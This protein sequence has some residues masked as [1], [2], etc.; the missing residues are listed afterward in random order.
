MPISGPCPIAAVRR[1]AFTLA[2]FLLAASPAQAVEDV[3]FRFDGRPQRVSGRVLTT[4]VDGGLLV[5]GRDGSLWTVTPED[6]L[7]RHAD[8]EPFE[9]YSQQELSGQ[10]I[11]TLPK[12]F[13]VHRT[14]HYLVCYDT[15]KAYAVWV[16]SLFERLYAAFSNYWKNRDFDLATPRYPLVAIVFADRQQYLSHARPEVGPAADG[17]IGYYSLRTN[18]ITTYDLTGVEAFR[19][20]ES[21]RGSVAEINRMLDR[22]Q[23]EQAVS[24]IIHEATHQIAFNTEFQ[25]RFADVPLW[26]SEGI[27]VYFETP[28]LKSKSGWRNIGGVNYKRLDQFRDYHRNRRGKGSLVSLASSDDRFRD[29]EQG[30]DAYAEAW[31]FNYFLLRNRSDQYHAY[32]KRLAEKKP[33]LFSEPDT[34]LAEFKDAFGG[35]LAEL[36]QDFLRYIEKVK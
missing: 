18:R 10:L 11:E 9:P 3:L 25:V 30:L 16:G 26:V 5:E 19:S 6:L 24:T 20:G 32:L 21:R 4:A 35:D 36:D 28:D 22:P 27:A 2:V 12:G 29:Q 17:I 8:S 1:G 7:E 33:L 13:D 23:A 34:R 31:A 14:A 15:S